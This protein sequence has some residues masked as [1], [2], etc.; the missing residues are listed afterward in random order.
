MKVEQVFVVTEDGEH[1]TV[2]NT[3]LEGLDFDE[4]VKAFPGTPTLE[5]PAKPVKK[6]VAKNG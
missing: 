4:A 6:A 1:V 5:E 3:G 2:W